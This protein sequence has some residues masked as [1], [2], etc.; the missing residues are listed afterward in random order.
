M[1]AY[2]L[3]LV[4]GEGLIFGLLAMGIYIAF[5]WF[6]FPDLTP[7]GSFVL[8]ACAYAKAVLYGA[9]PIAGL[10]VALSVGCLAG[11]CTAG[12]NR[13]VNIPPVV[14][15]LLVSTA[16]YSTSWLILGK[17]NQFIDSQFTLAGEVSGIRA[18][19]TLLVW[20][21]VITTVTI[22]VMSAWG[23][24]FWGL[25]LRAVGEN[26]LLAK[27]LNVSSTAYTFLSLAAANSLVG[28]AGALFAQR[29]YSVDIN[30]GMGVTIIGLAGMLL[31]LALARQRRVLAIV[32]ISIAAGAMIFKIVTF[33]A[34]EA[35]LPAE[36]FRLLVAILLVGMFLI[37]RVS[38]S[39]LL[40]GLKWN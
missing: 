5:Q 29:S 1:I 17:P 12:V 38:A 18:S 22:V 2:K 16:L 4:I 23:R 35:G 33:L 3:S 20:L 25:R 8:G 11:C 27:D 15:G 30:M 40:K 13:L 19:C 26:P 6:R 10:A 32:C 7:D 9:P 28:L 21:V 14:S 37:L 31:G 34:L 39:D 24:S 36:S